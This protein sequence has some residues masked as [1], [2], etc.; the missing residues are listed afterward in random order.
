VLELH[1]WLPSWL[2]HAG[3][4]TPEDDL[5]RLKKAVLG[6][7]LNSRAWKLYAEYGDSLL[8]PLGRRWLDP[9]RPLDSLKN[10]VEYLRLLSTCEIDMAPPQELAGAL[11]GC[12]PAGCPISAM[13]AT[14]FRSTWRAAIRAGYRGIAPERFVKQEFIP[15][16]LWFFENEHSLS[17]DNV[18]NKAGW[19][20]LR[21]RWEESRARRAPP[22]G[23]PEWPSPL[24]IAQIEGYRFLPLR[25]TIA[26]ENEG[27]IMRHCV[28]SFS[29]CCRRGCLHIFSV[30][31]AATLERVATLAI[32]WQVHSWAIFDLKGEK[33]APPGQGVAVA[34]AGFLR[35]VNAVLRVRAKRPADCEECLL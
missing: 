30:R 6:L 16:M 1:R 10:S 35:H 17:L 31:D 11:A 7:G 8:R 24:G 28:A 14:L 22:P 32:Q 25:S 27:Q 21:D 18:R 33:N 23:K 15:A 34:S 9:E 20:W 26:L 3:H 13:P 29:D 2:R 5:E 4:D 12:L 19:S